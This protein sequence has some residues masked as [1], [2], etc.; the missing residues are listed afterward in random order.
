[1]SGRVFASGRIGAQEYLEVVERQNAAAQP[2]GGGCCADRPGQAARHWRRPGQSFFSFHKG[3]VYDIAHLRC[4]KGSGGGGGG[5]GGG[6]VGGGGGGKIKTKKKVAARGK[7]APYCPKFGVVGGIRGG[8]VKRSSMSLAWVDE[9]ARGG[10][11]IVSWFRS[12]GRAQFA[13]WTWQSDQSDPFSRGGSK[14]FCGERREGLRLNG[15]LGAINTEGPCA[16][17]PFS[18]LVPAVWK[19]CGGVIV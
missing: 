19:L 15:T 4:Q 2:W 9:Q 14:T 6:G 18:G 12:L 8:P 3:L 7:M 17:A 10:D 16:A 5:G 13:W 1:M 11:E